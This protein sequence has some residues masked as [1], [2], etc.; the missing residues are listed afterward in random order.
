MKV[1]KIIAGVL[2]GNMILAF[3][4]AGFVIPQGIVMGGATGI[5]LTV[6]HYIS[7]D[8]SAIIF[9]INV[10]LFVLGAIVLGKKFATTT[11]ISTI[12]YPVFLKLFRAIPGVGNLTDNT[13][14]AAIYAGVL[15]G[16]GIGI[17]IRMGA[18]TGGTDILAL[19]IN[20]IFHSPLAVCMYGV[21][22]IVIAFQAFFSSSE[23]ILYGIITLLLTSIVLGRVAIFGQSQIQLFIISE[24]YDEIKEKLLKE[25]SVGA[26][27]VKIETGLAQK[28]QLGIMCVV[29]NRKLY[30]I[31]DMIQKIDDKA[32]ITITQIN[33]VKGRGFT[34][35]RDYKING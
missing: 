1:P 3:T 24:K 32:F 19:V 16:L 5:G 25:L 12:V 22:F 27:M 35:D 2:L 9:V 20:K 11:I 23:Q 28:D 34:L 30:T 15:F 10:I 31:N 18:S 26:T 13:L 29:Q 7:M 17:I 4:V 6:N 21:D 14:L 8:L 33:E